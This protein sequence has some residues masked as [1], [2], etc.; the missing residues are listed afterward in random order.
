MSQTGVG[1]NQTTM[2]SIIKVCTNIRG[3]E[4]GRQVH[5]EAIKRGFGLD[6]FVDSALIDMYAKCENIF[7][8]R[9]LFD[10]TSKQNLVL[11]NAMI[12]GYTEGEEIERHC[13]DA[14]ILFC[15]MRVF[16]MRSNEFTFASVIKAC[17]ALQT[18]ECGKQVHA[19]I[20]KTGFLSSIFVGS[21]LISMHSK[22]VAVE[23]AFEVFKRMCNQDKQNVISSNA[24]IAGYAQHG[25]F[26][27]ALKL[28]WEM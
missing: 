28:L 13:E 15:Q 8:A 18:A 27:K 24:M 14:L 26:E 3:L 21:A 23:D 6:S 1:H 12:A 4:Q 25:K 17:T 7:D 11:W 10:T 16:G 9:K 20:V 19:D 22:C 5:A 2:A